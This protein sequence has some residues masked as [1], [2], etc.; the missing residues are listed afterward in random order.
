MTTLYSMPNACSMSQHI[1]LEWIGQAYDVVMVTE[2]MEAYKKINPT[3]VVPA[4]Q[5]DDMPLMTQGA[6][7]HKFLANS[8]PEANIGS[9][10]TPQGEYTLD[11]ALAFVS[12][13]LHMSF[14]AIFHTKRLTS[15]QSEAGL[16]AVR[17]AGLVRVDNE[18]KALDEHLSTNSYMT[19]DS[20]SVADA[21]AF[22]VA[23]WTG[24]L[25]KTFNDY[26]NIKRFHDMMMEDPAVA[27]VVAENNPA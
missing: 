22:T 11:K 10:G 12:S 24:G 7:L 18:M 27:K 5:I 25:E 2:N 19:G 13:D 14:G 21:Y 26:P 9:D 16:V 20:K 4:L 17:E 8:H 23:R 6:A 1:V 3:G 15:D